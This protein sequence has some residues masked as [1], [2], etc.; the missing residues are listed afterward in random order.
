MDIGGITIREEYTLD[1][2]EDR[3]HDIHALANKLKPAGIIFGSKGVSAASSFF[4]GSTAEKLIKIDTE[5]PLYVI[6]K[7]GESKGLVEVLKRL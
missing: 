7:P 3:V 5:F 6:R 2:N 1:D 4:I